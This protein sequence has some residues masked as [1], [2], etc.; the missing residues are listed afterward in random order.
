MSALSYRAPA[1]RSTLEVF[2]NYEQALQKAGFEAIY[3]CEDK[4]CGGRNFNHSVGGGKLYSLFG[5]Q[6][7][8]RRSPRPRPRGRRSAP[9]HGQHD[10]FDRDR[11]ERDDRQQHADAGVQG[12]VPVVAALERVDREQVPRPLREQPG[13]HRAERECPDRGDHGCSGAAP[14]ATS[15]PAR[16]CASPPV[17]SAGGATPAPV[18]STPRAR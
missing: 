11:G 5:E 14:V 3:A 2:R 12:G 6:R 10:L 13:G 4:S 16:S 15:S 9:V 18:R 1:G 17:G 7:D 8:Q